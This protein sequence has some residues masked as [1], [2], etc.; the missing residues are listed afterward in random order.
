[1]W[2]LASEHRK[3]VRSAT[4]LGS[5]MRPSG[6]EAR[7]RSNTSPALTSDQQGNPGPNYNVG[8]YR[9]AHNDLFQG[10]A[11]AAPWKRS[12]WAVR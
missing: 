12:L 5:G 9:T 4:S 10:A 7:L 11:M 6:I 2:R 8:Y 3:R 1:M